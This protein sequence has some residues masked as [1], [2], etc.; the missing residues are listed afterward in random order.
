MHLPEPSSGR[1]DGAVHLFPL[2]AYFED[3]DAGGIVYHANYLRWFERART[4]M[5][6]SLGIDQSAAL[7][8]GAGAYA[9]ADLTI[10]YLRPARLGD[11]VVIESTVI[12][13]GAASWRIRQ[14]ALR[15]SETSGGETLA[16]AEVRIGFIDP[17]GRARAQP[18]AW[19]EALQ[20]ILMTESPT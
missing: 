16:T 7:S 11:A 2:R 5:V 4:E 1:F 15:G 12:A 19:R 17:A 3:T 6:R 13:L 14:R 18:A 20:T 10:R 8:E 9:V